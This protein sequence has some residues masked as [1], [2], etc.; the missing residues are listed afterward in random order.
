MRQSHVATGQRSKKNRAVQRVSKL[1]SRFGQAVELA[2][3]ICRRGTIGEGAM[4]RVMID[5]VLFSCMGALVTGIVMA[6]ATFIS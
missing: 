2:S 4:I 6:A 5:A 3:R 1:R